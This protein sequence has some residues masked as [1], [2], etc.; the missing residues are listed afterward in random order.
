MALLEVV[1]GLIYTHGSQVFERWLMP[2]YRA[3]FR[4]TGNRAD[5]QDLTA[6]V[7]SN[8]AEHLQV[9]ESVRLMDDGVRELTAEAVARHW[10]D[11]Y[12]LP[13]V[14]CADVSATG[15]RVAFEALT[16]GLTA[17]MRLLVVLRFLRRRSPDAIGAQLRI[18]PGDVR[19]RT[20]AALARVAERIGLGPGSSDFRQ[21]SQLSAYVEDL[22]ARRR[23]VRFEVDPDAWPVMIAAGQV[24]A[25][26]AGNDLPVKRFIRSLERQLDERAGTAF[27]TG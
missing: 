14:R 16:D 3:G 27:V 11:R 12:R 13:Q 25:A 18:S 6:W 26:I 8:V 19:R 9:P 7:F 21:A 23:P 24:Q 20:L 10:R 15:A 4:W 5:T 1:P 22:V 2:V 17:E